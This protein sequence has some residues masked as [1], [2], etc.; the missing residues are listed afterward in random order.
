MVGIDEVGRGCWAGPLLVVAAKSHGTLPDGLK[1]SKLLSKLQRQS[2]K[3]LLDQSCSFGE[4]W[5]EP[6]EIDELGLT[7]AMRLA[8]DRALS[9]LD[10]L[11]DEKIIMDGNYNFCPD[12]YMNVQCVVKADQEFPLV[13]AASIYAKLSR[14]QRM[15][16]L[17]EQ[18]PEYGFAKHV[19]YGTAKHSLALKTYG[20]CA[21]H[22]MSFKPVAAL[23]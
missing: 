13:S 11:K 8:V 20:P 22:R 1:D 17:S 5:V 7:D 2:F 12:E 3:E 10:V 6:N 14:D 9:A 16:E 15:T 18:Y 4:G 23:R 19:G 21:I